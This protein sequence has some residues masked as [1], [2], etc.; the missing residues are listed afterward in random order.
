MAL[1]PGLRPTPLSNRDAIHGKGDSMSGGIV[2]IMSED[3]LPI[4]ADE[5]YTDEF[6]QDYVGGSRRSAREIIPLVLDLVEVNRVIDV[7]CGLGTWLSVFAEY[8]VKDVYGID[9]DHIDM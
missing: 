4:H 9:G 6:Y 7:G 8:G 2:L 1:G 5:F 3:T